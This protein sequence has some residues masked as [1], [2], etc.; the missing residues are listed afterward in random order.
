[1]EPRLNEMTATGIHRH[2][3]RTFRLHNECQSHISCKAN[4]T[5]KVWQPLMPLMDGILLLWC[6]V[7]AS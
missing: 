2:P 4:S 3:L 5:P 1:M 6:T 7:L